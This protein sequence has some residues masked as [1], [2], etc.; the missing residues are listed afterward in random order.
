MHIPAAIIALLLTTFRIVW[1]WFFDKKPEPV[2]GSL[3]WQERLAR[4][5]HI[6]F[7]IVI[8]GMIASGIGMIVLNGAGPFIF[9][10]AG[11]ELPN[12]L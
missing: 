7:Y 4:G 12:V 10:G 8:L 11:A 6:A 2:Q 1:W 3:L 9:G 5:V